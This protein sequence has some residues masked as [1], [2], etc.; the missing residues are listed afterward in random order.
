M[1]GE[2]GMQKL[3]D[4]IKMLKEEW[5]ERELSLPAHTIRPHQ[6]QAI[7][8]LEEKIAALERKVKEGVSNARP[9]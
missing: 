4:E 8:E 7:E 1:N 5:R 2:E 3:M 9:G 6:I